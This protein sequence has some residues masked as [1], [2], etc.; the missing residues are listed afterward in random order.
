[1]SAPEHVMWTTR[2]VW[3]GRLAAAP[4]AV[5]ASVALLATAAARQYMADPLPEPV[6]VWISCFGVTPLRQI[7][8][9]RERAWPDVHRILGPSTGYRG[10]PVPPNP[11][12]RRL[13]LAIP[14]PPQE[15]PGVRVTG[16]IRP[17]TLRRSV[18][19]TYPEIAKKARIQ[20]SVILEIIVDRHGRVADARV[21]RGVPLGCSEAALEAVRTW[22]YRPARR[23]NRPVTVYLTVVVPFFLETAP[24]PAR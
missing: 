7:P 15:E 18:A 6:Q 24:L 13:S 11:P 14:G 19:P 21:L 5:L 12:R 9:S 1:M 17:P 2:Q 20:G 22:R 23:D 16:N 4:I 8:T 10:C 3:L